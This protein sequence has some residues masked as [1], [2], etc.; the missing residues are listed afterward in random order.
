MTPLSGQAL[1][2]GVTSAQPA[3]PAASDPPVG[4]SIAPETQSRAPAEWLDRLLAAAN[5]L[6][7]EASLEESARRVLEAVSPSLPGVAL[8]VS[9]PDG[10]GGTLA[11]RV[12]GAVAGARDT[13]E[14]P[15]RMFPSLPSEVVHEVPLDHG[16]T[17]HVAM[18]TEL[19]VDGL[20]GERE[21]SLISPALLERLLATLG[22]ALRRTRALEAARAHAHG[23]LEL[24]A[25]MIHAE[26]LAG[27]GQIAAGI[28]HDLNTPLTT[29]VAYSDYLRKKWVSA[30]QIDDADKQRLVRIHE[31]A[32]RLL[33][34]SRDL[35]A[36]SRPSP[37]VPAPVDIHDVLERAL[38]FCEHAVTSSRVV[39]ERD[40]DQVRPVRGVSGQLV[41]VFVNLVTN[42]CQAVR[43]DGTGRV[44]LTT[45]LDGDVVRVVV[46]DDGQGLPSDA[47]R[48][49]EPFFTTKEGGT[50]LGLAIVRKI[51]TSHG[52]DVRA[53]RR[54]PG[55]AFVVELPLAAM[56]GSDPAGR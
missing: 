43:R 31:A 7:P 6:A 8:G 18:A 42:A 53:E 54:S 23:K 35:M 47:E 21:A 25:K 14:H 36:Y 5:D 1:G 15:A 28:V 2:P 38:A 33:A 41:Q 24:E 55:T 45:R 17:L 52:G 22:A 48:L 9:T 32:E 40:Y 11:V 29:V 27:L 19:E 50:G 16:T 46:A 39:I 30:T 26:R 20:R 51:V 3:T 44:A 34:F 12:G 13:V 37:H 49:F 10:L 56:S 4:G